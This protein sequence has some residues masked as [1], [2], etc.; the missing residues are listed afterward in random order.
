VLCWPER[1]YFSVGHHQLP[2]RELD[3]AFCHEQGYPVYQRQIGGGTVLLGP[4]QLFYQHIV[5][6]SRAP[7]RVEA[8]Y[9]RSLA[10]PVEALRALG[11]PAHL[12]G[13]NEIEVRGRRIAGT[14]GGQIGQAMVVTG[15]IL[16][17]FPYDLMVRAWRVP[18]PAFRE[19]AAQGLRNA[20][21]TLRRELGSEP[22]LPEVK[23]LLVRKFQETLGCG[24]EPD[25]L[26]PAEEEAV[27][28][29]ERELL[30][31]SAYEPPVPSERVL[32]IARGVYVRDSPHGPRLESRSARRSVE[33]C[34]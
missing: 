12:E 17:D 3:L 24:L 22:P 25:T 14:G 9:R 26:T 18:S 6:T 19:L 27:A 31:P 5:H 10:A 2:E 28:E 8:I 16:L 21:T 23:G 34:P 29:A 32:K 33:A 4:E 30:A 15:N 13:V 11:L 1:T 20:L 7:L